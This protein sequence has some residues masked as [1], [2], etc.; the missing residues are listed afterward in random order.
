MRVKKDILI[1]KGLYETRVAILED[2]RLV[3]FY[4]ERPDNKSF[5]G[6]IYKG[7][8]E[9]IVN[10]LAGAFVSLG[11]MKNGLLPFTDIPP[12]L[13]ET[14][15][16]VSEPGFKKLQLRAGQE[17]I[18]QIVKDPIRNKGPRLSSYIF[19]P[20][21][22][23]VLMPNLKH[24]GISKR[25]RSH[26][27][28]NRLKELAKEINKKHGYGLIIRTAAENATNDNMLKDFNMLVKEW[29]AI[30]NKGDK[31]KAPYM[32][33]EEPDVV[34]K[35][36][37]D[38]F[39]KKVSNLIIDDENEYRKVLAYLR[40]VAPRMRSRVK[41]YKE[42]SPLYKKF[43]IEEDIKSIFNRK[44]DLRSG[45]FIIIEH[46]EALVAIDVN[47][48]KYNNEEEPEKLI[49]KTNMEAAREIAK[50]IRLRD[51][52]GL[53]VIDFIDMKKSENIR[54][55]LKELKQNLK[56]DR[57]HLGFSRFSRFGLLQITRERKRPALSVNL[58]DK[59]QVC[60][61]LGRVPSRSYTLG[62]IERFL[63]IN[64]D[65][66]KN[67]SIIIKVNPDMA[68]F[69]EERKEELVNWVNEFVSSVSIETDFYFHPG[70]VQIIVRNE[71]KII[72][73][74]INHVKI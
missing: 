15:A 37:R 3:E 28:R 42:D 33:Y 74:S 45:G 30:K 64:K 10:G 70:R 68:D 6:R 69:L 72:F 40:E 53:I 2:G 46:T 26:E 14:D 12:Q 36:I 41:L 60:N 63:Q 4:Y 73:D 24:L 57:A 52:A 5:V 54:S 38:Q 39:N 47:T 56:E 49:F 1:N 27:E 19:L 65:L 67:K 17:I 9:N 21:R 11:L 62:E 50:Q 18:C 34:I 55:V 48:G 7:K 43:G 23:L 59:C 13:Q 29:K 71:D 25:I 31:V 20:G 61:G 8:V 51:L 16:L 58:T 44:I 32:L 35:L 66:I 22:Y